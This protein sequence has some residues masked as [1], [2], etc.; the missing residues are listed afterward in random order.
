MRFNVLL[1]KT[2]KRIGSASLRNLFISWKYKKQNDKKSYPPYNIQISEKELKELQ[3]K[4]ID[5]IKKEWGDRCFGW[6]GA[7]R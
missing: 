5:I 4:I 3:D 2:R 7:K 6:Y 1:Y